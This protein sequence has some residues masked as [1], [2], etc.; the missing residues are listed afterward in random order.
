MRIDRKAVSAAWPMA[1]LVVMLTA[2]VARAAP[3]ADAGADEAHIQ[4][5]IKQ[6]G[7]DS[8]Q[9]RERA[10]KELQKMGPPA[11][12]FLEKALAESADPEV[13]VRAELILPE[14]RR[15][16]RSLYG[17]IVAVD[18]S[19]RKVRWQMLSNIHVPVMTARGTAYVV[20]AA[21]KLLAIDPKTGKA[22]SGFKA[23]QIFGTPVLTGGVIYAPGP[24]NT[25][26]A[27]DA[28]TGERKWECKAGSQVGFGPVPAVSD[29]AVFVSVGGGKV[30]AVDRETGKV[31][32]KADTGAGRAEALALCGEV[33]V[34][35]LAERVCGLDA[36]RGRMLW[37]THV[38]RDMALGPR[39]SRVVVVNGQV[40][41][42]DSWRSRWDEPGLVATD[43]AVCLSAG[44]KL[45][46]VDSRTGRQ[47]WSCP[48]R[49]G[50]ADANDRG[51]I[52]LPG[53]GF[54][55]IADGRARGRL[56]VRVQGGGVQAERLVGAPVRGLGEPLV[57]GDIVYFGSGRG[58]H[59][60]N[61]RTGDQFWLLETPEAVRGRPVIA[62][63]VIY[64]VTAP[65][66]G[67]AGRS[68]L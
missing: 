19:T 29:T 17:G 25:I 61:A 49:G 34:F 42:R 51:N 31:L 46:A 4:R 28:G 52:A 60:V 53:G 10:Q 57:D 67:Q 55:R 39:V 50:K 44:G 20:D 56:W 65:G 30:L 54:V 63:G 18:A 7:D 35:R 43:G 21:D 22:G 32:W 66:A 1:V 16:V 40:A 47:K 38:P 5:L 58:L 9:V 41:E 64:F 33:L 26:R 59:A 14:A 11:I 62:G 68:K 6:L 2:G 15:L 23:G 12:P 8:Y 36:E 37:T 13:Q 3:P 27:L 48:P 45:L 24:G